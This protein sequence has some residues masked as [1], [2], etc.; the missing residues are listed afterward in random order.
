MPG[1]INESLWNKAVEA[2]KESYNREPKTDEDWK[3]V[4]DV[5]KNMGGD[6]SKKSYTYQAEF[7]PYEV[8]NKSDKK[9]IVEGY[10][11]TIDE[12]LSNEVITRSGQ[13]DIYNQIIQR[14]DNA[15]VTGDEE[16]EIFDEDPSE[17]SDSIPKVKFTDA[18]LTDKGVW[19]RA[20]INKDHP[21]IKNVWNSV[22]NKFLNA[23]SITFI[24]VQGIKKR[25][26]GVWKSFINKLNLINITLTGNPMNPKATFNPVM[27]NA[28][29]GLKDSFGEE[30]VNTKGGNMKNT[31]QETK[32]SKKAEDNSEEETSKGESKVEEEKK[33]EDKDVKEPE[34]KTD[35]KVETK[36]EVKEES[37]ETESLKKELAEI[38]A[39]LKSIKEAPIF[40]A[41]VEDPK[42]DKKSVE[43]K[44]EFNAFNYIK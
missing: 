17:Y 41:K 43:E 16:H 20:E 30:K 11:S 23:F 24:P 15:T 31:E 19:V 37:N 28:L 38:K 35:E 3:I 32:V 8:I 44:K 1:N 5:Y 25:V 39:E 22:K 34:K 6:V 13:Q 18:E 9:Y 26:D 12:D 27:K 4:M 2:F 40:K 33:P 14:I 21:N 7:E 36:S 10:V 29:E 42:L